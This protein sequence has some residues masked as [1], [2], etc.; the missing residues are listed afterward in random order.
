MGQEPYIAKKDLVQDRENWVVGGGG[1]GSE[2]DDGTDIF[3]R[4]EAKSLFPIQCVLQQEERRKAVGF[5]TR[6]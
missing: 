6:R 1:G 5:K 4:T 2:D 3:Q